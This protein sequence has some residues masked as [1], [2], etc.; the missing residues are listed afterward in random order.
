M[1]WEPFGGVGV[2]PRGSEFLLVLPY[3]TGLWC[4]TGPGTRPPVSALD[5]GTII[6]LYISNACRECFRSAHGERVEP[7]ADQ[8][9]SPVACRLRVP[10]T[11]DLDGLDVV[12]HLVHKPVLDGDPARYGTGK[13]S[14]ESLV[15]RGILMGIPC[16]DFEQ[17]QRL[18]IFSLCIP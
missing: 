13:V 4:Y 14:N 8:R 18:V 3:M 5:H 1:S 16:Q 11:N 7:Y 10:A 6:E 9:L 2:F 17:V 15:W 12:Q